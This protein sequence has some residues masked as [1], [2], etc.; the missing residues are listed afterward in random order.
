MKML[1]GEV[2]KKHYKK[3]LDRRS[4]PL[5]CNQKVW[6]YAQPAPDNHVAAL[7]GMGSLNSSWSGA[8]KTAVHYIYYF[9]IILFITRSPRGVPR[10][11]PPER[12][13]RITKCSSCTT[14]AP[15]ESMCPGHSRICTGKLLFFTYNYQNG[16]G[17]ACLRDASLP[18]RSDCHSG[19]QWILSS[20]H[21]ANLR[22]RRNCLQ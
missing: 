8:C 6:L 11:P 3:L 4:I 21:L 18:R 12:Q 22:K 10:S 16:L 19:T 5:V 15:S 2:I 9:L 14:E 1:L 7:A 20:C 17:S 13:C